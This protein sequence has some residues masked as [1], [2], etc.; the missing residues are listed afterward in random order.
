LHKNTDFFNNPEFTCFQVHIEV[1]ISTNF[2]I[3]FSA[4]TLQIGGFF[5]L[6]PNQPNGL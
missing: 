6:V 3:G 5:G 4:Q 1:L 2:E